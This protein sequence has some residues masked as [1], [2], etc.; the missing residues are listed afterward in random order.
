VDPVVQLPGSNHYEVGHDTFGGPNPIVRFVITVLNIGCAA[1]DV[2]LTDQ[3]PSTLFYVHKTVKQIRGPKT[4]VLQTPGKG[5]GGTLRVYI[6]SLPPAVII[7]YELDAIVEGSG[8][9]TACVG[10][11]FGE[12]CS[13]PI[14]WSL[15]PGPDAQITGGSATSVQGKASAPKGELMIHVQVGIVQ[16]SAGGA[17]AASVRCRWLSNTNGRFTRHGCYDPIWL[18]ARGTTHWWLR[19]KPLP[20]G[21]YFVLSEAVGTHGLSADTFAKGAGDSGLLTVH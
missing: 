2:E 5:Y 16:S 19:F 7:R 6:P 13:P 3:L 17:S 20:P 15:L 1:T 21:R 14:D 10:G 9:N 8:T 18:R 4:G 12:A 11:S